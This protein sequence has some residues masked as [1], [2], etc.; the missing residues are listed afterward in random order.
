MSNHEKNKQKKEKD[1]QKRRYRE[2]GNYR[3]RIS[4]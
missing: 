1:D 4:L 3:N 2:R